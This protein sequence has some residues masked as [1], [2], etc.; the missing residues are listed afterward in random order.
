MD[1]STNNSNQFYNSYAYSLPKNKQKNKCHQRFHL[2]GALPF[3]TQTYSITPQAPKRNHD[4]N[5]EVLFCLHIKV[6]FFSPCYQISYRSIH[7]PPSC[8]FFP[9]RSNKQEVKRC[10]TDSPVRSQIGQSKQSKSMF[11]SI[12]FNPVR[13]MFLTNLHNNTL[14]FLRT[15]VFHL[16]SYVELSNKMESK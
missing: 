7:I 6:Q 1:Q 5:I 4:H 9:N 2:C 3:Q 15:R 11:L 14:T 16:L 10:P 12:I 8:D 13:T